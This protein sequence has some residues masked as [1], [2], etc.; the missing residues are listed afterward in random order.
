MPG[1]LL[2]GI[3]YF[4]ILGN[5]SIYFFRIVYAI[6]VSV[7]TLL[8]T[9]MLNESYSALLFINVVFEGVQWHLSK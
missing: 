2:A 3:L 4:I 8:D 1:I 9:G 7:S 5:F 6:F